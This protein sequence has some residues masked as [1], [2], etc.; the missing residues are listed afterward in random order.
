MPPSDCEGGF[1]F[2]GDPVLMLS[3][4]CYQPV[5]PPKYHLNI[6]PIANP[7]ALS[8]S[9]LSFPSTDGSLALALPPLPQLSSRHA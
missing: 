9:T 3:W 1:E 4:H 5:T 7:P 6:F 8:L 2:L